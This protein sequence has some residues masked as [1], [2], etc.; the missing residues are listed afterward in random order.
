MTLIIPWHEPEPVARPL[1]ELR[2]PRF[3]A[4]LVSRTPH[5]KR[6]MTQT[7]PPQDSLVLYK[8]RPAR[9]QH[10]GE[11]LTLEL[12]DGAVVR[13]RPKDVML[14]HTGPL[15]HLGELRRPSGDAQTAWELLAGGT[16]SLPELAELAYGSFTPATAWAAWE[17]V[18]DG[19]YFR[20]TPERIA[21]STPA[22]VTA[23]LEARAAERVEREAWEAFL[24]RVQGGIRAPQD[25][26]YLRDAENLALGRSDR[27]R[28]LHA[29]GREESPENAHEFLLGLGYWGAGTNPHPQRLGVALAP[30]PTPDGWPPA[31][32]PQ[33]D[34]LDL[35]GLPAFAIDDAATENPDDALSY[36]P[37]PGGGIDGARLWVHVADPA[38]LVRPDDPVDLEARGRGVTLHL[39]E[40]IVPML[41]PAATPLFGL[42]LAEVS[43]ALSIGLDL[44]SAGQAAGLQISLS[45][46]RVTR[47]T[48]EQVEERLDD[49]PFRSLLQ[50][51]QGY[52]A[53]RRENGAVEIDLPEVSVRLEG[54]AVVIRPVAP[55]RSRALVEGA[56]IMAGEA[57]ARFG[58]E[59]EIPLPYATQ[60]AP[61]E[62][63]AGDGLAGMFALRKQMQRSQ[64][65]TAPAPHSGLGLEAYVQVTSPLRRYL[66]LVVHQ[67]IRA[68]LQGAPSL[69]TA[70]ILE[71][72][73]AVEAMQGPM[74][75]AEQLSVRHWTLV[76]LLQHPGWR[77]GAVLVEMRRLN[78]TFIIPE[79][80]M[81]THVRLASEMPIGSQVMLKLRS[82]DLPRLEARMGIEGKRET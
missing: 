60:Q 78:G 36:A 22:E 18:A 66:D 3:C 4:R 71:R 56:M 2:V 44:D 70:E 47:L 64:V 54:E 34:R 82:V 31:S 62:R 25:L 10:S 39:P 65:K 38:A 79:L 69:T 74:R 52:A 8:L 17:L 16:T 26:R 48:Y 32:L 76:Y 5:R 73:G 24:G 20:G 37:G 33:E 9:V 29:L 45:W 42:G 12:E 15:Q 40:G 53:R 14:L 41:P 35:T 61:D 46:V 1:Q 27:S 80:A 68:A 6:N 30:P 28:V 55:L 50:I 43:P 57:V 49:D 63:E 21:A 13:V 67:Q 75:Q 51:A 7:T 72:I 23:A 81:E 59:H 19:L 77:G 58:V 11:K